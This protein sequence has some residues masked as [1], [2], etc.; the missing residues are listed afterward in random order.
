MLATVLDQIGHTVIA[1]AAGKPLDQPDLP[2]GGAQQ[3]RPG[4]RGD[5]AAIESGHHRVPFNRCK[6]KQIRSTLCLH[7]ASPCL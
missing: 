3:Q 5:L 2:V 7:R 1:K 4:L 6:S